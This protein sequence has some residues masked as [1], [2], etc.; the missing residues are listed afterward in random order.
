MLIRGVIPPYYTAPEIMN[1]TRGLHVNVETLELAYYMKTRMENN[2][3]WQNITDVFQGK[4]SA[5]DLQ[6][7]FAAVGK[8]IGMDELKR[9]NESINAITRI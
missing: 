2:P 9:L 4:I 8:Q 5:F 1:D 7:E 6:S 3:L